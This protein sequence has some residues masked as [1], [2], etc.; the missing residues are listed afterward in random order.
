MPSSRSYTV[1]FT[2]GG[3]FANAYPALA[4]LPFILD[5]R[6]GYHRL[7]NQYLIDRALGLWGPELRGKTQ[8]G[9]IPSEIT[10]RNYA[11]WL[12]N[13]LEWS[14]RRRVDILMLIR[15][16]WRRH[17]AVRTCA[18]IGSGKRSLGW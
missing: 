5:S 7:G 13:F 3:H 10:M 1:T 14:D 18:R 16:E 2:R 9:R 17:L 4:P 12:A 11:Q 15:Y 6:P 8:E